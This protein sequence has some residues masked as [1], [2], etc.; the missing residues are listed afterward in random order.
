MNAH[1]EHERNLQA[2]KVVSI[3]IVTFFALVFGAVACF[4]ANFI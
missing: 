1:E 2:L 4:A 3:I